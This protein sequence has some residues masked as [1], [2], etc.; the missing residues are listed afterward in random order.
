MFSFIISAPFIEYEESGEFTKSNKIKAVFR[1]IPIILFFTTLFPVVFGLI[2]KFFKNISIVFFLKLLFN[3]SGSILAFVFIGFSIVKLPKKMFLYSNIDKTVDYYE[4]KAKIKN[5]ELGDTLKDFQLIKKRCD[6]TLKYIDSI[7]ENNDFNEEGEESKENE[8]N[9]NEINKKIVEE[10]QTMIQNEN[11]IKEMISV[12]NNDE[13]LLENEGNIVDN[14]D[15]ENKKNDNEDNKNKEKNEN[16][17]DSI[18]TYKELVKENR[19]LKELMRNKEIIKNEIQRIYKNWYKLRSIS[20]LAKKELKED[21]N[22]DNEILNLSSNES[23]NLSLKDENFIQP[24]DLTLK[25]VKSIKKLTKLLYLFLGFF[26]I[27]SD[28]IIVLSEISISFN[29]K[30]SIFALIFYMKNVYLINLF[31]IIIILF[32]FF[33]MIYGMIK[34]NNFGKKIGF[35]LGKTD[36]ISLLVFCRSLNFITVPIGLNVIKMVTFDIQDKKNNEDFKTFLEINFAK[37]VNFLLFDKIILYIPQTLV[38][39]I[40]IFSFHIFGRI[41]KKRRKNNF[42]LMKEN[43]DEFIQEGRKYLF[44]IYEKENKYC[45][46]YKEMSKIFKEINKEDNIL[47]EDTENAENIISVY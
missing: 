3:E 41:C 24:N 7:K 30:F 19:K 13:D 20:F 17:K 36:G 38:I 25:N 2:F 29:N 9:E 37:K 43:R 27:F 40:I 5:E 15:I 44:E 21:K 12:L 35:V 39:S 23:K 14:K 28:F 34:I 1:K 47:L 6:L 42:K 33:L 4:F 8:N 18:K 16:K 45:K 26:F 32:L 46:N 22:K 11:N 31:F 10:Q